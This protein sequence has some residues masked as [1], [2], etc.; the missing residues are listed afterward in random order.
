MNGERLS[1]RHR[2][3]DGDTLRFGATTTT[4]RAPVAVERAVPAP[5]RE[6]RSHGRSLDHPAAACWWR[7]AGPTDAGTASPADDQQ[8]ADELFL[9]VDVVKTHLMVL[10]A[11]FELDRLPEDQQAGPP[12]R[13]GLLRRP[14]HGARPIASVL[15][16]GSV[17]AGYEVESVVGSG[18]IGILYRARQVRL[19]RPVALKV[20]EPEVAGDPVVRERLRREARTLAALDHP[21][22]VPLYEAGEEDGTVFIATRWVDGTELGTLIRRD[23]PIEPARAARLAAQMASAL[24]VAHEKELIHRDVKP[25]NLIVTS[26][27]HVYLTDFGLTKRAGFGVGAHGGGADA[28]HRR[29]RRTGADRGQRGRRSRGDVYGLACVLFEMLTGAAPYAGRDGRDGQD[30]GPH[31]RRAAVGARGAARGAPGAGRPDPAR[32]W[33]RHPTTRPSAADF[34]AAG[35]WRP[36]ASRA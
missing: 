12:G 1:G 21:N 8:I 22:V 29:L 7:S 36:W 30:V 33:R 27:D 32:A 17:V 20:V 6:G 13:K 2:L 19:D 3:A 26:E 5:A 10:F 15:P 14:C 4:F 16:P 34:G 9:S 11:K 35:A 28:G 31:Q 18:G 25:S 24:E 23:G